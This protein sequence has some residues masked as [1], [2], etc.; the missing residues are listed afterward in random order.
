MQFLPPSPHSPRNLVG[1][2]RPRRS[3]WPRDSAKTWGRSSPTR[4]FAR[5]QIGNRAMR[6]P[7]APNHFASPWGDANGDL[8]GDLPCLLDSHPPEHPRVTTVEG[9]S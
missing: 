2:E 1:L 7:H 8:K 5:V 6:N 4:C 9:R 3:L